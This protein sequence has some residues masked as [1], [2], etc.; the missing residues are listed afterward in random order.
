MILHILFQGGLE[1]RKWSSVQSHIHTDVFEG[2]PLEGLD[3]PVQWH[4][5]TLII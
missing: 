3:G 4:R 2:I 1:D 5:I